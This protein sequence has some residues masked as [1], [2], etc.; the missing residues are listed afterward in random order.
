MCEE[1]NVEKIAFSLLPQPPETTGDPDLSHMYQE[2]SG[3]Y[4]M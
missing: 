3:G 4:A 2:V 1:L